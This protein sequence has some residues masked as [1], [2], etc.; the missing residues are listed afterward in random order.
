MMWGT[1]LKRGDG[2]E[3]TADASMQFLDDDNVPHVLLLAFKTD[4]L[5]NIQNDLLFEI[6]KFNFENYLVKDFDLEIIDTG[7]GLSVLVIS[8]FDNLDELLD[9]HDRMDAS[10]SFELPDGIT[11]IDISDPNFRLLLRGKTF[12][13]YFDW[14]QATYGGEEG[15]E[16]EEGA[17]SEESTENSEPSENGETTVEVPAIDPGNSESPENSEKSE[18]SENSENSE[19]SKPSEPSE[20]PESPEPSEKENE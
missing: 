10:D 19:N 12:E 15:V 13:E 11:Q 7:N 2:S 17:E 14:V 5:S 16:G 20:N 18:S 6:A 4:S 3:E 9:Y 8:G 1:S